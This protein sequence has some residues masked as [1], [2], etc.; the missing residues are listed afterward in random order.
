MFFLV[1]V[2]LSAFSRPPSFAREIS[3]ETVFR[4]YQHTY[5]GLVS[6]LSFQ[7]GDW[8]VRAGNETWYWAGGRLLPSSLRGGEEHWSAHQFELYPETVPSP[9]SYSPQFIESLR[10]SG[11]AE[12]RLSRDD[13]HHGFQAVLYGGLARREVESNIVRMNFL[14]KNINVHRDITENLRRIDA[15]IRTIAAGTAAGAA[16]TAAFIASIGQIGGYNWREIRGSR[17]LSYHRWGLAVDIQPG[18]TGGKAVYW[19][20]EQRRNPLWMLIP[21]EGRW[22]PPEEVIRAFENEG[23]IWGGKWHLFDTMHFEYRPELHEIKRLM[24][25]PDLV[26]QGENRS[27]R[28]EEGQDLHHIFPNRTAPPPRLRRGRPAPRGR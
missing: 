8:T 18:G 19:L 26:I 10:D 12:A 14:G 23:F 13:Q 22:Q 4:A 11:G 9:A 16:E 6:G 28:L 5:P 7:N 27:G 24:A 2:L 17:R 21:P 20:W 3:G 15:R 25:A 1:L